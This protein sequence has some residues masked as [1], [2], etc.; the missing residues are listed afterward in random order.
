[1]AA[2]AWKTATVRREPAG[3]GSRGG[4]W[5]L[6]TLEDARDYVAGY[7]EVFAGIGVSENLVIV[8]FTSDLDEHLRGLQVSVEHPELIRVEQGTHP[9]AKLQADISDIHRRLRGDARIPLLGSRPGHVRLR[10]PL[11]RLLP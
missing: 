9:L 10:A 5:C 6:D 7:P 4:N 11:A 2:S 3:P 8:S 1:M